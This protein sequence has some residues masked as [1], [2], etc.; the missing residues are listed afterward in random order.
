M[1]C[2]T[3]NITH[4]GSYASG[5]F[6]SSKCAR[7]FSSKEKRAEINAKVSNALKGKTNPRNGIKWSQDAKDKLKAK[8]LLKAED[9]AK[10]SEL[11]W[12]TAP[13]DQIQKGKRRD[14]ILLEQNNS[15]AICKISP[16]WN[17]T[18]LVFQLD[19]ISG[20]RKD[21]SR[22]NLRLICPNCH[23]QTPTWGF[24]NVSEDGKKR[25]LAAF[26]VKHKKTIAE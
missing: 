20:N 4:D 13:W 21:E 1:T 15:C 11:R 6:C 25:M 17:N 19:H 7:S 22:E 8:Y 10:A 3:C 14:R 23:S 5:R 2:E 26:M 24:G 9:R 18:K 12:K 16:I